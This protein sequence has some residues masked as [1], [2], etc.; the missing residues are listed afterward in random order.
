M[1]VTRNDDDTLIVEETPWFAAIVISGMFLLFTGGALAS[2]LAGDFG[3]LIML[4]GSA[5][6]ALAFYAF[7]RRTMLVLERGPGTAR[8]RERSVGGYSEDVYPLDTLRHADVETRQDFRKN[9]VRKTHRLILVMQR[10][11]APSKITVTD[12][13]SSGQGAQRSAD[14]INAWLRGA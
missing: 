1:K 14:A 7:V 8:L 13:F 6:A 11:G 5:L 12:H 4:V 9:R 3:G 2:V 10:D